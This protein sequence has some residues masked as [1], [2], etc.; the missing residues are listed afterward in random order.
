MFSFFGYPLG[1]TEFPA[2]TTIYSGYT[3][4][5]VVVWNMNLMT[6]HSVGNFIIPTDS[7][8]AEG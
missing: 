6:F 7:Y 8:F 5:W 2:G 1:M 4:I 3:N